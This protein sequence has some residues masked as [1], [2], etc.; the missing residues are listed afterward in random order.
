MHSNGADYAESV[1]WLDGNPNNEDRAGKFVVL[2]GNKMR[3]ANSQ[4]KKELMGVVSAFPSILGDSFDSYWHGKYVTDVYGRIQYHTI[5]IPE[6]RDEQGNITREAFVQEEPIINPDYDAT[7]DYVSRAKR[8][9]YGS[10]AMLGKL[11]VEDDGTCNAG[12]YCYPNDNG[13]ATRKYEG[14]YVLERIDENH[15]KIFVR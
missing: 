12:E 5:T 1:E 10:F 11:V 14:F 2:E 8:K 13:I 3:I 4:D 7:L 15:I 6:E 9:E